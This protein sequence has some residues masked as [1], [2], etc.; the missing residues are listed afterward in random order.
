MLYKVISP[1]FSFSIGKKDLIIVG[2]LALPT[3][4][5][6]VKSVFKKN[7]VFLDVVVL[8]G[9]IV[10]PVI[11]FQI[12]FLLKDKT[13]PLAV[14]AAGLAGYLFVA[15]I[16]FL[17]V[18][19]TKPVTLKQPKENDSKIK[20][21]FTMLSAKHGLTLIL[22]VGT[23]IPLA[24]LLYFDPVAVK[25]LLNIFTTGKFTISFSTIMVVGIIGV[26]LITLAVLLVLAVLGIGSKKVTAGDFALGVLIV[27]GICL[28]IAVAFNYTLT[29]L[30]IVLTFLTLT[31]IAL[32]VRIKKVQ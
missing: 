19:L 18:D 16:R 20:R 32:A 10:L 31:I 29:R 15:N 24:V 21:Y 25:S 11:L 27:L 26:T 23:I 3:V 30:A 1:N 17:S 28:V 8:A 12:L 2:V 14:W 22:A 9:I 5:Y 13:L 7:V 6:A 4:I